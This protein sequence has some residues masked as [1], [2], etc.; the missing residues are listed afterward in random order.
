MADRSLPNTNGLDPMSAALRYAESGFPVLPVHSPSGGSCSCGKID[1]GSAG[2]HPRTPHGYKDATTD[3]AQIT[4]C[5][6]QSP[7]ANVGM[8]TG[9]T[10][11]LIVVDVDPRN[12]GDESL[13]ALVREHG[14]FP[15]TVQQHSGGGGL[16]IFF[17]CR[18]SLASK[19][20]AKGIDLKADG[21]YIVMAPSVH[22][23]GGIY[24]WAAGA[25]SDG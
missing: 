4:M 11:G 19:I 6:T 24:H 15:D 7:D 25:D 1:R 21:G 16:H 18:G 17:Q 2:K 20:L 22:V 9:T 14:N 13:K 5:W 12:G 23:T 3:L 10:S 8:P